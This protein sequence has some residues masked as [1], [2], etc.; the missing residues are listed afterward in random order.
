VQE[1]FSANAF[2]LLRKLVALETGNPGR[3]VE[4]VELFG[5]YTGLDYDEYDAAAAELVEKGCAEN[6]SGGS[7]RPSLRVTPKGRSMFSEI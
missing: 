6:P 1:E 2:R 7:D 4:D 3:V 5:G